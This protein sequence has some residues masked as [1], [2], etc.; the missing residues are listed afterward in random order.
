[1]Q[2]SLFSE[3]FSADLG[4]IQLMDDLGEYVGKPGY[5]M[6]GGGNPARIPEI[7]AYFQ[8]A[9]AH[10]LEDVHLMTKASQIIGRTQ[11]W[12]A[13]TDHGYFWDAQCE[14]GYHQAQ[15]GMDV[16]ALSLSNVNAAIYAEL[17]L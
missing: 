12:W 3:K 15:K 4:V 7:E 11:P 2:E 9:T 6:L 17:T 8:Q 5:K 13:A 16:Q 14:G 10:L 1:M